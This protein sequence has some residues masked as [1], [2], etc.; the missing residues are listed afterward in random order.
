[1]K[2]IAVLLVSLLVLSCT[3]NE[4]PGNTTVVP[5]PP[6]PIA[7]TV[8]LHIPSWFKGNF[9]ALTSNQ[10]NIERD[11][12]YVTDST[13]IRSQEIIRVSVVGDTTSTFIQPFNMSWFKDVVSIKEEYGVDN[14]LKFYKVF[15][16]DEAN[17]IKILKLFI[18][19]RLSP[20]HIIQWNVPDYCLFRRQ[21]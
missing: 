11:K 7:Q 2:K 5:P 19:E 14:G 13:I 17:N 15:D 16:L 6:P 1:M 20:D 4:N 8:R 18:S 21:N 12:L 9:Y 3:N 10:N